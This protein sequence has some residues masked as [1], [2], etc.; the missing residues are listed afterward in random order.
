MHLLLLLQFL[1]FSDNQI[2]KKEKKTHTHTHNSYLWFLII[3][4]VQ[5]RG[6]G[7]HLEEMPN[8]AC[9]GQP[10]YILCFHHKLASIA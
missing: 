4:S 9:L 5:S 3:K 10:L 8:Q 2:A 7:L 1:I 6:Q